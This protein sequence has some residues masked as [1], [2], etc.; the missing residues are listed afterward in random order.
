MREFGGGG[1]LG[2][3]LDDRHLVGALL[4]DGGGDLSQT[5]DYLLLDLVD[6]LI[7]PK[8]DLAD[9]NRAQVEPPRL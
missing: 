4:A 2:A 3:A 8:V 7:V 6:H 1:A 5:V 9:V